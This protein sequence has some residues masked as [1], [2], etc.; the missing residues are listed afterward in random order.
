M[1]NDGKAHGNLDPEELGVGSG[2]HLNIRKFISDPENHHVLEGC[3]PP[4]LYLTE[5]I[6]IRGSI[7]W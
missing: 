3:S 4:S 2:E 7:E 1:E 5:S 6:L